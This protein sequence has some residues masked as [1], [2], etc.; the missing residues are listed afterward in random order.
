M[1]VLVVGQGGREHAL[2]WK[3]G[4]SPRLT[5]IY[6][7]PGNVGTA[8]IAKSLG[9]PK[10][11]SFEELYEAC[12]R[13]EISLAVIGPEHYLEKGLSD[14]LTSRGIAVFG[15][16]KKAAQLESSKAFSK[17]IMQDSG[18]PT[19]SFEVVDSRRLCEEVALKVLTRDG[20]V[21]LKASGLASG[22]GVFVC[23]TEDE[24]ADGINRLYS[25]D[26]QEASKLVVVEEMLFGRECSY[27]CFLGQG[28]MTRLGFA[29]DHKRLLAGDKGPNTGGMGCYT[30]VKWLPED[31][32]EQIE[33]RVVEPLLETLDRLGISYTGCLYVGVMWSD[34]GPS[35]VEFNVRL[36][37]PEA[38][39]L[40]FCDD[41]DWLALMATKAGIEGPSISSPSKKSQKCVMGYV[42]A[43][44]S[45]PYG[46]KPEH[47][48][49]LPQA[50]LNSE[51]PSIMVFQ[52]STNEATDG[53]MTSSGR[54][55]LVTA[56]A[57]TFAEARAKARLKVESIR[58]YWT[59]FQ[60]RSDMGQTA[61]QH[62]E[63]YSQ[64]TS[65]SP[66][67]LGSSSPR[68]R[69]LLANLGLEFAIVKPDTEEVPKPNEG[70]EEYVQRNAREKCDAVIRMVRPAYPNGVLII[71]ADTIVAIDGQ[72]LEKPLDEAHAKEMLGALSGREHTVYTAVTCAKV[73]SRASDDVFSS[74][75]VST[76]VTIKKLSDQEILGYIRTKEPFD[77]AGGYAAQGLGSFMVSS[78]AGS[79]SNVVGL[80][81]SELSDCLTSK[82]DIRL[83]RDLDP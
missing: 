61:L 28:S 51:D 35:V 56:S 58:R 1:R 32:A 53:V 79:F 48:S 13:A 18:I 43:S 68:R 78:V 14:F 36:G 10:S 44:S 19:A 73:G 24:I 66:I 65:N 67:V 26:M 16:S 8:S 81:L 22:K 59:D 70:C 9:L 33:A 31:A 49:F 3:L 29:V 75:L 40:A 12:K 41:F 57:R 60:W 83:W 63:A 47:P 46:D 64:T 55:L 34:K 23:H 15:P 76:D 21:V 45:Y 4:Q 30:P 27:F 52:A 50:A 82:F 37:D 38:Q 62:E 17:R 74:F 2:V 72:I 77:K 42:L 6:A 11:A 39:V 20:G 25:P 80:P 71:C 5:D 69:E 7:W 54:V